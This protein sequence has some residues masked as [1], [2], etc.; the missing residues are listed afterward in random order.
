MIFATLRMCGETMQAAG[1]S[2]RFIVFGVFDCCTAECATGEDI[3]NCQEWV[4]Y[5]I[6]RN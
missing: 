1:E 4:H 5:I 2:L 6:E 3:Q